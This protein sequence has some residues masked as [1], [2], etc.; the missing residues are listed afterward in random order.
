MIMV[1]MNVNLWLSLYP[2]KNYGYLMVLGE[3]NL[4]KSRGRSVQLILIIKY[5]LSV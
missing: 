3:Y 5:M 1:T 2:K 4:I